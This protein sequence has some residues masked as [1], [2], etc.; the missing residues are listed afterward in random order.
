MAPA[1]LTLA[2]STPCSSPPIP[3]CSP[4]HH[5]TT[6][7]PS[8]PVRDSPAAIRPSRRLEFRVRVEGEVGSMA[9]ALPTL[10]ASPP[11][12]SPPTPSCS[13]HHHLTTLLP[14]CTTH[15]EWHLPRGMSEQPTGA[16]YGHL[17]VIPVT[18]WGA[19]H[20]SSTGPSHSAPSST[21]GDAVVSSHAF[22]AIG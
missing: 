15:S 7:M 20:T 21:W 22:H 14:S 10:A 2:A 6:L 1:L 16:M 9:P 19:H 11:C 13:P 18:V 5:L 8:H 17:R 3:S 12:P 4:H